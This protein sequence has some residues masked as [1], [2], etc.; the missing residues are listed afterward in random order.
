M[1]G[2]GEKAALWYAANCGWRVLPVM[3]KKPVI[4]NWT[5]EAT[6]DPA[7]IHQWWN[8]YPA[9][10]V[11]LA[12][13]EKSGVWALD[14]DPDAGGMDSLFDLLQTYGALPDT[15]ISI[16]GRGGNHYIFQCP[17]H[18][19]KIP[20][21][22]G[23]FPGIDIRG[24]GGQIVLPPST[25]PNGNQYE[26]EVS[27][28]P[29]AI[30]PAAAPEWLINL[31]LF[32]GK[33]ENGQPA[34]I[35][36]EISHGQRHTAMVSLAGTF[37][38]RG[39]SPDEIY[40]ALDAVNQKRCNPP[41]ED[42]EIREIAD[43]MQRYE[44][45]Q[46]TPWQPPEPPDF[47]EPPHE[48]EQ[49]G[50]PPL[51][52]SFSA[53]DILSMI[54]PPVTWV[55][56]DVLPI[57]LSILAGRPKVG[58]SWLALQLAAAVGSGGMV[59]G[60]RVEQAKVLY[61]ALEDDTRRLQ[62]RMRLQNWQPGAKVDFVLLSDY[63]KGFGPLHKTGW[64]KLRALIEAEQYRMVVIDT[65]SR[66][67]PG[68][69]DMDNGQEVTAA[70][71]PLQEMALQTGCA[72]VFIDHHN[73]GSQYTDPNPVND[74]MSSTAKPAVADTLM[75]LYREKDKPYHRLMMIGRDVGERSLA[76]KF[77][78]LTMCWQ[79]EGNPDEES[80]T[81]AQKEAIKF[82]EENGPSNLRTIA[83]A[84]GQ[85]EGNLY[86]QLQP[87]VANGNLIKNEK[88]AYQLP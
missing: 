31:I 25:H 36:K 49:P 2:K 44:A 4:L 26:W 9:A 1:S 8:Q 33:K 35:S 48:E 32:N 10:G 52:R 82:I 58:K 47:D 69:K 60:K 72:L 37:R 42:K 20:S 12:T 17:N 7:K 30:T 64:V 15:V 88:K 78:R 84:T 87:L 45:G 83:N 23:V 67:F 74:I 81:I 85:E 13:G 71:S 27:S 21:L 43:S 68:V 16:T 50:E 79:S 57:G 86:R 53:G 24:E 54:I 46:L 39:L 38:R 19:T 51:I 80:F 34:E 76:L 55:V 18:G 75:G 29:D 62:A 56:P 41:L 63:L 11:G 77:E 14:I 70:L 73:K 3:G 22:T 65:L 61:L 28:R 59:F 5:E 40:T 66:A 6:T